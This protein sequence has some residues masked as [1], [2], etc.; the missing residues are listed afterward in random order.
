MK[1]I[2][3]IIA[4]MFFPYAVNAQHFENS[5]VSFDY[6]SNWSVKDLVQTGVDGVYFWDSQDESSYDNYA[7]LLVLKQSIS[8]QSVLAANIAQKAN[9][10]MLQNA[11]FG[12]VQ[13]SAFLGYKTSCAHFSTTIEGKAYTGAMHAFN[14]SSYTVYIMSIY[15]TGT[16][17]KLDQIWNSV[18]WNRSQAP[19][20]VQS[21]QTGS[22]YSQIK[23]L[24]QT[25]NEN[26]AKLSPI[27]GIQ[28][29]PISMYENHENGLIFKY[30]LTELR[31]K[32][33]SKGSL[34]IRKT[35]CRRETVATLKSQS[36]IDEMTRLAREEKF[37]MTYIYYDKEEKE[38]FRFTILPEEYSN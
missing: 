20:I 37:K 28:I 12:D 10:P 31:K 32:D 27:S 14:E 29:L 6:P 4:C 3:L 21:S 15:R 19:I 18:V 9:N 24:V 35:S 22:N 33:F 5:Y 25:T 34:E 30:K 36:N 17:S 8:P 13:E 26:I 1:N 7:M 23:N 38:L 16:N 11:S 2:L